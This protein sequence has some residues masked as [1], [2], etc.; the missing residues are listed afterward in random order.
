MC[1]SHRTSAEF[2]S[3]QRPGCSSTILGFINTAGSGLKGKAFLLCAMSSWESKASA[4]FS[5][6][7]KGIFWCGSG[8]EQD[9]E[10]LEPMKPGR[11]RACRETQPETA[12]A[13][14][15]NAWGHTPDPAW[16][17]SLQDELHRRLGQCRRAWGFSRSLQQLPLLRDGWDLTRR[18]PQTCTE[19]GQSFP[20]TRAA[21][22][23]MDPGSA[24]SSHQQRP[25]HKP[26]HLPLH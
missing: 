1:R 16:E 17:L 2:P 4:F 22:P 24:K 25:H 8:Q 18:V 20:A 13:G 21:H 3:L 19:S 9:S 7:P 11:D 14:Q 12:Q 5:L 23:G 10:E 26:L 6:I 15:E